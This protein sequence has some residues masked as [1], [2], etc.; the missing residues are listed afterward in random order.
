MPPDAASPGAAPGLDQEDRR[1]RPLAWVALGVGVACWEVFLRLDSRAVA[2]PTKIWLLP[3]L[4]L[5]VVLATVVVGGL[6]ESLGRRF[7]PAGLAHRVTRSALPLAAGVVFVAEFLGLTHYYSPESQRWWPVVLLAGLGFGLLQ[8][9]GARSRAGVARSS[10]ASEA[11][12][13]W[14]VPIALLVSSAALVAAA[15][16]RADVAGTVLRANSVAGRTLGRLLHARSPFD[17]EVTTP[18]VPRHTECRRCPG[19]RHVVLISIDT[20][21]A[22][23]LSAYDPRAPE[24]PEIDRLAAGSVVFDDVYVQRAISAPSMASML[25]GLYPAT[26]TVRLNGMALP[27]EVAT[28]AESFDAAG[29]ATAGFVTN[30]HMSTRRNFQ[31]GFDVYRFNPGEMNDDGLQL[32]TSDRKVVDGALR[33]VRSQR[34]E[35][36]FLWVHL[37]APHS[38]YLPPPV[39]EPELRPG[40]G[41]WL[42]V[43]NMPFALARLEGRRT[44]FD[45]DVYLDLYAAEVASVDHQVGRLLAGLDELGIADEA[46]VLFT[47]DHGEAFGEADKF[48]HGHSLH[49]VETR[50]PLIWKLP[51]GRRAGSRIGMTVQAV[52]IAPTLLSLSELTEEGR[53]F[54]GRDI[55]A[56]LLGE[57]GEDDGFAFS[58]AGFRDNLGAK[59]HSYSV[60]TRDRTLWF[61]SAIRQAAEFDRRVDPDERRPSR[62]TLGSADPLHEALSALAV[63][64]ERQL[65]EG[66][67]RLDL[68][69]EDIE[70][71][72]ALGYIQ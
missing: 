8:R 4:G 3:L 44:Y 70:H 71:M 29:Y 13:R 41:R 37:H 28:L 36:L 23:F 50:I 15:S 67:N 62:V 51:G 40:E 68:T 38:P 26:H 11:W 63:D 19:E 61:D 10:P 55:S 32:D 64:S 5:T 46:H 22:D 9:W 59:G 17:R 7:L 31:Q 27:G 60:R 21:R 43:W 25:T 6:V 49:P 14:A 45:R 12:R 47:S 24:T 48:G 56:I 20:L 42:N 52:D 16:L 2:A 65:R 34:G 66:A 35:T 39:L 58:E 72:R 33:W 54:D 30:R 57:V 1:V 69:P 53:R 18:F